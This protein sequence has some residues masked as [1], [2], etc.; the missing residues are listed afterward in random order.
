MP[1]TACAPRAPGLQG[2]V[3]DLIRE[4]DHMGDEVMHVS[5]RL[6][7]ILGPATPKEAKM[8]QSMERAGNSNLSETIR[9]ATRKIRSARLALIDTRE[10]IDL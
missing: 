1:E 2:D 10:R 8:G 3:E 6:G 5:D 4:C 9:E 7:P